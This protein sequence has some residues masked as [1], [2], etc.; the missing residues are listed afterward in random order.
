MVVKKI[1]DTQLEICW[2]KYFSHNVTFYYEGKKGF[3]LIT[4][5]CCGR[6]PKGVTDK[7]IQNYGTDTKGL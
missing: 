5:V 4:M 3:G 7:Y 6:L 1:Y 2:D